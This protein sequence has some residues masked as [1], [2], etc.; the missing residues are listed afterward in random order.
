M[1]S[2]YTFFTQTTPP[3]SWLLID[4]LYWTALQI[5]PQAQYSIDEC[6]DRDS[7]KYAQENIFQ[8]GA[9]VEP[10]AFDPDTT[11]RAGLPVDP[12]WED[13]HGDG[14]YYSD[15]DHYERLS[16]LIFD[17]DPIGTEENR[18]EQLRLRD[19]AIKHH[20][21]QAN[22]D[23]LLEDH[24]DQYISQLLLDLRKGHLVASGIFIDAKIDPQNDD[25]AYEAFESKVK[26]LSD[27]F[28][29]VEPIPAK[30]WIRKK[31]NFAG[32]YLEGNAGTFVAIRIFVDDVLEKYPPENVARRTFTNY[33]EGLF[34]VTD[35]ATVK[36]PKKRGRPQKNWEAL[37][38]K[39][40][41]RIS[42][43]GS[44]PVKQ[45]AFAQE[46]VDWYFETFQQKIG[47]ST[48]KE[49]LKPYY[50]NSKFQKSEK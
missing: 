8:L 2:K 17:D 30:F 16:R 5:L 4:V 31:T 39:I 24:L 44:L 36:A 15:P 23:S 20:Q 13:Y 33:G 11:S 37:S 42:V 35:E 50:N 26:T 14:D 7:E 19:L 46:L 9:S 1:V 43:V 49:K 10:Y 29:A 27:Y 25:S 12:R 48:V 38:M 40:A 6:D 32:D 28:N 47:L 21:D 41:E 34:K 22:W 45:D 3:D 18:V